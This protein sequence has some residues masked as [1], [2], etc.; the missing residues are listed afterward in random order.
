MNGEHIGN[1]TLKR[2]EIVNFAN[3]FKGYKAKDIHNYIRNK[4]GYNSFWATRAWHDYY[5]GGEYD[6]CA[7]F[8]NF[9]YNRCGM[10]PYA[11]SMP[12]KDSYIVIN[13]GY[14]QDDAIAKRK[15]KNRSGY[16]PKA[17]DIIFFRQVKNGR[18][19]TIEGNIGSD[20]AN[21]S[22]V[23]YRDYSIKDNRI[24]GYLNPWG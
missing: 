16:T 8:V 23:D 6:W 17:G 18:V 19:Y 5:F 21:R 13:C 3:Q 11:I 20:Y 10:N 14:L 7:S 9:V 1:E 12:K 22:I 4:Y 24:V 15:Y 2:Q